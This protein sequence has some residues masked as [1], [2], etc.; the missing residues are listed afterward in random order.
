MVKEE[1]KMRKIYACAE[2]GFCGAFYEDV[3]EFDDDATEED[4]EA[5]I[6]DWAEEMVMSNMSYS[7]VEQED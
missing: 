5:T 6:N 1:N 3:F 7:W 4:I 2:T